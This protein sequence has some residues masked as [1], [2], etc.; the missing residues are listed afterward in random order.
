VRSTTGA[1]ANPEAQND[2]DLK[3]LALQGLMNSSPEKGNSA[4]GRDSEWHR[5]AA[6]Q[7]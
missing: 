1:K 5:I 2:E 6:R 7:I 3:L 4:G